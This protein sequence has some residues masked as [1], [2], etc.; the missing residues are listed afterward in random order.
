M[1][2]QLDGFGLSAIGI[3]GLFVY[4][5]LKGYSVP[6]VLQALIRGQAPTSS[7]VNQIAGATLTNASSG[8]GH[9]VGG[10]SNEAT[11]KATAA[12]FGWTGSEWTALYNVEMREAGFNLTAKNPTS[13]A[14]GMAQFINGP[15]EYYQYGGDPNTAAGQSVAMCNYIEQRYGTPSMA[16]QHEQSVGWY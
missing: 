10:S 16:W 8:S 6:H 9:A 2:R 14:Y 15:S 5:G 12:T 3:G 11:L 4:A 7:P 1:A 13:N